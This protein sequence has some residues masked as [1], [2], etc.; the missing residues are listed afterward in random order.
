MAPIS[1]GKGLDLFMRSVGVFFYRFDPMGFICA[2]NKN[3]GC[4]G[5]IED[6]TTQ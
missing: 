3:P 4:L 1:C 5:Y 6:Y 2:M